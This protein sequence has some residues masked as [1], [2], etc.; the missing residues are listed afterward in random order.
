[1]IPA[2][3]C[4]LGIIALC[5]PIPALGFLIVGAG[6]NNNANHL[7][8]TVL[9]SSHHASDDKA[10]EAR[11]LPLTDFDL[12]RL[13]AMKE[14]HQTIPILILE[15]ILPGQTISFQSHDPTLAKLISYTLQSGQEIG[16]LGLNPITGRPMTTGVTVPVME[17]C[18]VASSINKALTLQVRGS[19]RF[20]VQGTPYL[21]STRSFFLA[22]VEVIDERPE[23]ELS[24]KDL[25]LSLELSQQLPE[26]VEEWLELVLKKMVVKKEQEEVRVRLKELLT[27]MGA[28]PDCLTD[29]ALWIACLVNPTRPF[30]RGKEV[31]MEIRP[32]MLSCKNDRDRMILAHAAIV[33]CINTFT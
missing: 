23:P 33:S 3:L 13:T 32:A 5:F 30:W 17:D 18:I 14:R 4:V 12:S 28:M 9:L 22:N 26:L 16:V 15:T 31:C 1:M 7:H 27:D 10:A 25:E 19:K 11:P 2:L 21:D 8:A 20:E 24:A 6:S 29:R